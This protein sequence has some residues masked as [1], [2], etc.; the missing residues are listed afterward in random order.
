MLIKCIE[1][2]KEFSDKATSCPNCG[3]PIEEILSKKIENV[4]N[5]NV[6]KINIDNNEQ[7]KEMSV[8]NWVALILTF[9]IFTIIIMIENIILGIIFLMISVIVIVGIITGKNGENITN[10][11]IEDK[12]KYTKILNSN[13]D[14]RKSFSSS[15]MRGVVGAAVFGPIGAIAG[16]ASGKNKKKTEVTFLIVYK[17]D[18][19]ETKTVEI[20]STLYNK[21]IEF[22]KED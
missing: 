10:K 3:C 4:S 18:K 14:S 19:K 13:V 2:D 9:V 15:A 16:A 5:E 22:L 21:Y 20:N 7:K 11:V 17:S 12:I 6:D 8:G 1:C